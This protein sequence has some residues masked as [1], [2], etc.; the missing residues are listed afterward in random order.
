[1]VIPWLIQGCGTDLQ[2]YLRCVPQ[3]RISWFIRARFAGGRFVRGRFRPLVARV[4]GGATG[5]SQTLAD[6]G[7][8][9][10]ADGAVVGHDNWDVHAAD[11]RP[12]LTTVDL[13][14]GQLG[15]IAVEHLIAASRANGTIPR[16]PPGDPAAG[17]AR[18]PGVDRTPPALAHG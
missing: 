6:P 10:P 7:R 8:A 16:G 3:L 4:R 14:L 15:A 2:F 17:P 1:V 18:G 12:P 11:C 5:A 9:I 13:N